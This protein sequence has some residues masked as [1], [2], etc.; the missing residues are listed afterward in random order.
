MRSNQSKLR[1]VGRSV[2][3]I[4]WFSASTAT[5]GGCNPVEDLPVGTYLSVLSIRVAIVVETL[6][7]IP[8]VNHNSGR[9]GQTSGAQVGQPVESP[10]DRTVA[11]VEVR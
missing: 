9:V 5:T 1:T 10:H 2:R 8:V 11:A 7:E 4:E 3:S 6:Q